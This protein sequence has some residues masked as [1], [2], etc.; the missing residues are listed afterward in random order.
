MMALLPEVQARIQAEID[1]VT[2]GDR[3]PTLAD[4]DQGLLPYTLATLYEI[5]RWH[6][7]LPIGS[8]SKLTTTTTRS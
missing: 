1:S 8:S 2:G 6:L 7:P 5:F 4:R 3:L